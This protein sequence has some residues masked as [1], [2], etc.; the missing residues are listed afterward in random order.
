MH[1]TSYVRQNGISSINTGSRGSRSVCQQ[2]DN[3][4]VSLS[5]LGAEWKPYNDFVNHDNATK[6]EK[7]C[8]PYCNSS[9]FIS[10]C[11]VLL[12]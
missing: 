8:T 2:P 1:R 3:S 7:P 6:K 12:P 10:V 9:D 5:Q 4:A 11:F